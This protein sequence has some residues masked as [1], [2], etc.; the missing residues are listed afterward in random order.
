VRDESSSFVAPASAARFSLVLASLDIGRVLADRDAVTFRAQGTCM[1]ATVRPGDVLRVQSRTV[2]PV[3]VGDLAVC[4]G[5]GFLF[6]HRVTAKGEQ[7]GRAY[8]V[9][10]S[11][12]TREGGDAPTFDKDLL[13]VVVAIMRNGKPMPLAPREYAWPVRGYLAM[14][15]VL[16]EAAPRIQAWLANALSSMQTLSLYRSLARAWFGLTRPHVLY[17]VRLPLN[18][19][20]GDVAYR[21][22]APG[23]FDARATWQGRAVERFTLT[24]H[25]NGEREPAACAT[26][27]RGAG[28]AWRVDQSRVRVRY[29]GA[30]FEDA[31]IR[32]AD[33]ILTRE[34]QCRVL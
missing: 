13:G 11:D 18:G 5:S 15:L 12:R 34:A 1:Y 27:A 6:G 31:L 10:R 30:G 32:Q 2:A 3:R 14:R 26:F 29:R 25:L 7:D 4:R 33:T 9:T 8:V 22:L 16:I 17:T 20:L 19:A 28:N 23:E 24:L 21:Q